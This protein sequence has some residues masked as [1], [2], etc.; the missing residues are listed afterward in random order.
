MPEPFAKS[1]EIREIR[2]LMG[3]NG[4]HEAFYGSKRTDQTRASDLLFT[5]AEVAEDHVQH[6]L[7]VNPSGEPAERPCRQAQFFRD[8]VFVAGTSLRQGPV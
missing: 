2:A 3:A 4:G 6:V 7:D 8:Q 5:D 1:A